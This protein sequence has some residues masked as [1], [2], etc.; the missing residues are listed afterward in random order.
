[1]PPALARALILD[2]MCTRWG[3]TLSSALEEDAGLVLSTRAI[4]ELAKDDDG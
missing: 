4:L 2:E 1:M 3:Y